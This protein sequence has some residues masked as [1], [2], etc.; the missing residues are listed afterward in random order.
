MAS[1]GASPA[2]DTHRHYFCAGRVQS[3]R[4][5]TSLVSREPATTVLRVVYPSAPRVSVC[6]CAH[7][8]LSVR[9]QNPLSCPLP[10]LVLV[11]ARA[12]PSARG[13][14]AHDC[15][16]SARWLMRLTT[17]GPATNNI[18]IPAYA[19]HSKANFSVRLRNASTSSTVS[20]SDV[21]SVDTCDGA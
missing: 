17:Y 7:A 3:L 9:T 14:D 2:R 21:A 10:A 5:Y 18:H 16:A 15:L 8:R 19:V 13:G 11:S 4:H 12:R 1:A 20:S 6:V